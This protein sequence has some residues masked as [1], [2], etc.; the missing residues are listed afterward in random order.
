MIARRGDDEERRVDD[1]RLIRLEA[2]VGRLVSDAE[3]EKETRKRANAD[4]H[5]RFEKFDERMRKM[6]HI[7]IWSSGAVSLLMIILN[8]VR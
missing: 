3:S 5:E 2:Q 1:G 7:I 6:E 8:F 4:I